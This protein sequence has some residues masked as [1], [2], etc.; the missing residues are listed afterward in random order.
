M[1]KITRLF[2]LVACVMATALYG[3]ASAQEPAEQET[4]QEPA[5]Q[6]PAKPE[7]AQETEGEETSQ[8]SAKE[9]LFKD[10]SETFQQAK[11][12]SADIFSPAQ[13]AKAEQDFAKAQEL[14]DVGNR[15]DEVYQNLASSMK[16]LQSAITTAELGQ[17]ALKDLLLVRKET[18]DSGLSLEDS[19][20]FQEAEKK[21]HQ[22]VEKIE[23]D[24]DT[25]GARK[26][27][28]Q[29]AEKYRKAV[30]QALQKTVLPDAKDKLKASKDAYSK[31][32]YKEAEKSLK[33]FEKY[34]KA[35]S[36]KEFSVAELIS[37]VT[38][39]I[40]AALKPPAATPD[41]GETS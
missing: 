39:G 10:A 9:A 34:V 26:P 23:K 8:P 27:S 32:A 13:Y 31:D 24:H 21:F 19:K 2:L 30:V 33:D 18:I 22:A 17:V 38:R 20:D 37:I 4:H 25:K 7:A 28:E 14:Y 36:K 35:E 16:A 11:E 12:T 1:I 29:A 15:I 41:A 6:E 5:E 40:E 3:T